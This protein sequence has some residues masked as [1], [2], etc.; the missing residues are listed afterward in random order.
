MGLTLAGRRGE[1]KS[2]ER[3]RIMIDEITMH[4]EQKQLVS[5][6]SLVTEIP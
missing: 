5:L 2:Y 1:F 6:K 3:K 4:K